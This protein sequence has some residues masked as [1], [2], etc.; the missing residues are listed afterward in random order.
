MTAIRSDVSQTVDTTQPVSPIYRP[1]SAVFWLYAVALVAGILSVS[2]DRGASFGATLATQI[3]LAWLWLLFVALVLVV[4]FLFDPYRSGRSYPQV[5][6]AGLALGGTLGL[7]IAAEANG[8]VDSIN[9]R[10]LDPEAQAAWSAALSA[11]FTEEAA[12]GLCALVVLVLCRPVFN[13]LAQAMM[14]GMFVGFGFDLVEDL[15]YAARDALADLDGDF[16]AVLGELQL[17]FMTALPGHW[18]Y[19]A[20]FTMGVLILL[21]WFNNP[22][23]WAWPKR[24]LIALGL[25]ASASLMHFIWDAPSLTDSPHA[26]MAVKAGIGL[27][28]FLIP[29]CLLLRYERRWV[30]QAIETGRH[31]VLAN[32]TT[33]LLDSLPTRRGRRDLRRAARRDGGRAAAKAVRRTQNLALQTIQ[34]AG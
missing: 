26:E 13:R 14:L 34:R 12:K 15:D 22:G 11:P 6:V 27:V 4:M 23:A 3:E 25:M 19:T 9:A 18:A 24:L 28:I 2:A 32:F 17:R 5:L 33:P 8:A 16:G 7:S 1:R 10:W 21:P 30:Q 31:C 20:L 29:A